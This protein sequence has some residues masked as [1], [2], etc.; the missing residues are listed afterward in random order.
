[1]GPK[2]ERNATDTTSSIVHDYYRTT[3]VRSHRPDQASYERWAAT[4]GR[5]LLPIILPDRTRRVVDLACGTGEFLYCLKKAGYE[6]LTGVDLSEGVLDAARPFLAQTN[7]VNEDIF[8]YLGDSAPASIGIIS[9]QNIVEHLQKS[10]LVDFFRLVHRTLE[11]GGQLLIVV[12]NAVS[13]LGTVP[14]YWDVTHEIAFSPNSI[15]Q[16]STAAGFTAAPEFY[17]VG[18]VPHGLKSRLRWLAWKVLRQEIRMRL[19]IESGSART[20]VFTQ[21]MIVSLV[22]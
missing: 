14:R 4:Q 9:G 5:R 20:D 17:E 7:L 3:A 18:P 6:S 1:M 2:L 12:P 22:K 10:T 15:R 19:L 11:P 16:L 21:D 13:M 8:T